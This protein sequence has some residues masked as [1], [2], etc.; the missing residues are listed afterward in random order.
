MGSSLKVDGLQMTISKID[1]IRLS[2]D[3]TVQKEAK[4]GANEI[5]KRARS[6]APKRTGKLRQSI[7]VKRCKT[8]DGYFVKA[9]SY[10]AH[11][12]EYGTKRGIIAKKFMRKSR[13]ELMPKIQKNIIDAI[14]KVVGK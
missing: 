14:G 11:F 4:D 12:H 7:R 8:K 2:A 9:Y 5:R 13:D 1:E 6:L 3:E 10:F